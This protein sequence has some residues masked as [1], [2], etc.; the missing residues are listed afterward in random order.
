MQTG[1]INLM[2]TEIVH[3]IKNVLK[4]KTGERILLCN[5]T[6][7]EAEA[8]ILNIV[9][10]EVEVNVLKIEK[11]TNEP[12]RE[13]VLY[14]AVLKRENFELVAQKATEIGVHKIIPI[15]TE[16]T[17]KTKINEIRLRKIMQEAAEQAG[18]G[19]VPTLGKTMSFE[20][21][22]QAA[23]QNDLNVF[24]DRSGENLVVDQFAGIKIVGIFVG[25]EGGWT[26]KEITD[27][28]QAGQKFL[29]LGKTTLRGETA[30]ILAAYL[31]LKVV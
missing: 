19:T 6:G 29:S 31:A 3:Q 26:E 24:F 23:K 1:K 30:A 5:G 21:A 18:R 12:A 28:H 20:E 17:I 11:N 7:L 9:K 25:P 8:E 22:L 27:A 13:V 16:R 10:N 4:L 14:C 15:I 2:N